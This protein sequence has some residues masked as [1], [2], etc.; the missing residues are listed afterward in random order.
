MLSG[1]LLSTVVPLTEA[2]DLFRP[3]GT[4]FSASLV[5]GLV[6]VAFP[7]GMPPPGIGPPFVW[8]SPTLVSLGVS[9]IGP[10][11]VIGPARHAATGPTQ[12]EVDAKLDR[13]LAHFEPAFSVSA[14]F[15]HT[16][17]VTP[18]YFRHRAHWITCV[19]DFR[20]GGALHLV[21]SLY[22]EETEGWGFLVL[23]RLVQLAE[24]VA[25]HGAVAGNGEHGPD[26]VAALARAPLRP[27]SAPTLSLS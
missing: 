14:L 1:A 15:A 20:P 19:V 27:A 13:L 26:S 16:L 2:L 6:H 10:W 12:A 22:N 21:D 25:Q 23:A 5:T 9:L 3:P 4:L 18:L 7:Q 8:V 17:F 11:P 24:C